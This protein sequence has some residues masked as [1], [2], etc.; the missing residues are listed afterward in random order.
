L[1]SAIW[2]GQNRLFVTFFPDGK[3]D[4]DYPAQSLFVDPGVLKQPA[5]AIYRGACCASFSP[6][7]RYAVVRR[8]V[9]ATGRQRCGLVDSTT[10]DEVAHFDAGDG[11]IYIFCGSVS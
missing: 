7:G 9:E 2:A 6:D 10:G 3:Y 1:Q 4:A 8:L 11:D 5:P